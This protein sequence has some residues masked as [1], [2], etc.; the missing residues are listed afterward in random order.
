MGDGKQTKLIFL[1]L[2]TGLYCSH[3]VEVVNIHMESNI[4]SSGK[5]QRCADTD[6]SLG[7][8]NLPGSSC[9]YLSR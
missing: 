5:P 3:D 8:A 1:D 9:T 6:F 7:H 4:N 2:E